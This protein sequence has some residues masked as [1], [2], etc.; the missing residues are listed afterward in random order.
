MSI[1]APIRLESA[2]IAVEILPLGATIHRFEVRQ[3]DGVWRNIVLGHRRLDTYLTDTSYLGST[4]G[5]CASRID[6][7]RFTLDGTLYELDAN[8]PPHCRHGGA[9]GFHVREWDVDVVG[10]GHLALSLV[11]P[12][13]DQGFPGE[14]RAT[15]EYSLITGGV[16]VVYTAVTDA[17][18]LVSLTTHPYF[19]LD[20]EGSGTTDGHQLTLHASEFT[21]TRPDG[22]PTG[23]VRRVEG[24][25]ADFRSGRLLGEAREAAVAEGIARNDGFDH[26]FV[27]DGVGLRE[28]AVLSNPAGMALSVRSDQPALQVYG[29]DHLDGSLTGTSGRAYQRRAGVALETQQ[30]P[31]TANHPAF[32]SAVLQPGQ[33]FTATTQWLVRQA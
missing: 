19:N 8:E 32:P 28:C 14:V 29:G 4:L 11:S 18:T 15:A 9:G 23:E 13:G 20:G 17:P 26:N 12:D 25:A 30:F 2:D 3:R 10:A 21:P 24:T 16:Q 1:D 6:N 22:I 5:R 27:I 7:A 31:D 33:R